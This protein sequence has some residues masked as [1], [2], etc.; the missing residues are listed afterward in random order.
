LQV[1]TDKAVLIREVK[2]PEGLI[3]EN[4]GRARRP[5]PHEP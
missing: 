2:L 1:Q 5:S 4:S 3:A